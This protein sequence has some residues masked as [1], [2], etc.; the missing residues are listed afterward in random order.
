MQKI[1]VMLKTWQQKQVCSFF[2]MTMFLLLIDVRKVTDIKC[3]NQ[4]DPT[5]FEE[6][7]T[8]AKVLFYES[9]KK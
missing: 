4:F 8:G 9:S 1:I 3:P 2:V 7:V 5:L 6:T